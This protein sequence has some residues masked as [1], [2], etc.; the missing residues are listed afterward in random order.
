MNELLCAEFSDDEI[1]NAMFQIG[2]IK[3]PRADGFPTRFYQRHWGTLKTDVIRAIKEFFSTG[4]MPE[5]VNETVI[6]LITK[7]D[8]P[9][10]LSDIRPI[11]LCNVLYKVVSK[12]L[13]NRLGPLLHDMISPTQGAF[14]LGRLIT[15]NALIAFEGI[16]AIMKSDTSQTYL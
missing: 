4:H 6:V 14:I 13:F 15:D 5:L 7:K 16:H 12:C 10:L 8:N 1:S 3:A 2:P 9:D 11:S